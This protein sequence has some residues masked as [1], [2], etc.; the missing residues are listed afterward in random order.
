MEE[1]KKNK[2]YAGQVVDVPRSK[3]R[4]TFTDL[5]LHIPFIF[6]FI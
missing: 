5:F 2:K 6:V 1:V 4:I 3:K